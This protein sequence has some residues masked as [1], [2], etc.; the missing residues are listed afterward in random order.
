VNDL[1]K[2]RD[3]RSPSRKSGYIPTLDGWRAIA[4]GMVLL[5][6]APHMPAGPLMSRIVG[7]GALG[8]DLFFAISGILI[9]SRLLEEE[10]VRGHI[11][12]KGF[13][14][15]RSFR[16]FP[17]AYLYL[18]IIAVITLLRLVP[19]DWPAWW[20]AV[21]F[22][23]NYFAVF[24][25]DTFAGRF[26]GH[27][28][29]LAVEEHFYLLLPVALVLFPRRRKTVLTI[30]T[31]AAFAWLTTYVLITPPME[32]QH[33]WE[34]RSDLRM[35]SLLFPA[36]LALL[37]DAPKTRARFQRWVTPRALG[38][39][40][41]VLFAI[42]LA[43][44]FSHPNS[45]PPPTAETTDTAPVNES[46]VAVGPVFLV[47]FIFPFVILATMLHPSSWV[48]RFLEL[49]PLRAI[50]RISYSLY[51]WQQLFWVNVDYGHWPIHFVQY[52]AL[53]IL[54]AFLFAIGSYYLLEKP[55]IRLG[56]RLSPPATP[57]HAN[58][59]G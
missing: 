40:L 59:R 21:L 5:N 32:R 11:S 42:G 57:G 30:L 1:P 4:I 43:K 36:L 14:I 20:S 10:R 29:S 41:L 33:F 13:Y 24:V 9:C 22:V 53:G 48:S 44:H 27:F 49:S 19:H 51:I 12:L 38:V 39:V 18:G 47:P 56:H 25:R 15:R 8:V 23:R 50:G 46:Q 2:S 26:S 16:I 17:P 28:W 54:L 52:P 34:R 3:T 58:L 7:A 35:V 6:H 55:F 45:P 37:L 31:I